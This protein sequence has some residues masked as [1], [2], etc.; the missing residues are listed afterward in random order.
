MAEVAHYLGVTPNNLKR[1]HLERKGPEPFVGT[2]GR[3]FYSA[4]Q[5]NE[6][7]EYLDKN[8]RSDAKKYMPC[9]KGDEKLQVISVV[10]F[11]GGSGKTTTAAI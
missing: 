1:L 9:R 6:L 10:N 2:A 4:E 11:K 3:R 5:M 7:R 8:G